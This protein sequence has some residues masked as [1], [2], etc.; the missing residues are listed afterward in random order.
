MSFIKYLKENIRLIIFYLLLMTFIS[1]AIYFDRKNRVLPST[2]IY[3][4]FVSFVMFVIY[5]FTDYY[6]KNH[7]I[8][9]LLE[10]QSSQDKTPILPK[11]LNY[12]DE[13]Y[14]CI[15]D[16]LY[17][18]Y[19][20]NLKNVESEFKE[21]NEFITAWVHDIK[22]PITTSKLLIEND[23]PSP[24]LLK[25]IN[26]EIDRIDN[27]IEKVLYYSRCDNFSKDYLIS[28]VNVCKLINESIKKHS[29]IFIKK[30]IQLS[31]EINEAFTVDTDK[32]WLLFIIDQLLSN[33][34]KY[35]E[36]QGK[37]TFACCEDNKE[38]L[39]IIEDNGVGIKKEDIKKL[40][41]KSFT[42]YNGRNENL[43]STGLGLYL[44]QRL[45]KKLGHII[46]IESEYNIGTKAI[47]HFSKW[48]DYFDVT[49]M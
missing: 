9:D 1:F 15:I 24:E 23:K 25:S 44:S 3:I 37:I 19:I 40:F 20:I 30:H 46:T 5:I 28:E 26:E 7:H 4:L 11:P 29:I 38:K 32:K 2:H 35:T 6:I 45:A 16:N 13:I 36:N 27:Y 8:K 33:A 17:K 42:G 47:I 49:K 22:T 12:V 43:K 31:N 48:N 21:N 10:V 34:L 41:S 18:S 14:S 39:I